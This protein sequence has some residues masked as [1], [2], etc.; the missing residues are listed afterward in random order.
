[1]STHARRRSQLPAAR[2]DDS[3][4]AETAAGL[5]AACRRWVVMWSPWRQKFTG[6][7]SFTSEPVI[8]DEAEEDAFL[9]RIQAVELASAS[10]RDVRM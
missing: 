4:R 10:G 7:A 5:Q 1:M 9:K 2:Q 3:D 8:V 6:F